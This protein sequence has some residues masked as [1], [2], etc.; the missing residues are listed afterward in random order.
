MM[1]PYPHTFG[2][3]SRNEASPSSSVT[4][5]PPSSRYALRTTDEISKS[6]ECQED[7]ETFIRR[8]P[9]LVAD[10]VRF[11]CDQKN[12]PLV[13]GVVGAVTS[14][15]ESDP[16]H[17]YLWTAFKKTNLACAVLDAFQDEWADSEAPWE[18]TIQVRIRYPLFPED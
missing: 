17:E 4:I 12:F 13:Y 18:I 5:L 1:Q 15:T 10:V 11:N 16:N 3:N 6:L 14:F 7:I 2:T 8:T 9:H